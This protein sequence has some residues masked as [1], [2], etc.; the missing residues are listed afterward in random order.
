MYRQVASQFSRCS[1]FTTTS[2]TADNK[3]LSPYW[4]A[5]EEEIS[6]CLILCLDRYRAALRR[7]KELAISM[8]NS[9]RLTC[10]WSSAI[11]LGDFQKTLIFVKLALATCPGHRKFWRPRKEITGIL[12]TLQFPIW[13]PHADSNIKKRSKSLES[14]KAKY[15][16]C[17]SEEKET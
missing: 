9:P 16:F 13:S 3:C 11:N 2:L 8:R 15:C 4:T 12:K 14:V 1:A 10:W 5:K 6:H 7:R 17:Y